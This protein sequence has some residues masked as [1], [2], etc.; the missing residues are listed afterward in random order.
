MNHSYVRQPGTTCNGTVAACT[1]CGQVTYV[2]PLHDERGGPL[3][4][5]LCAG[6]WFAEHGPRRRARRILIKALKAY[7]AAGGSTL[8]KDFNELRLAANGYFQSLVRP[9][10]RVDDDF[11]DLTSELLTA[12]IA[13]THPDKHPIERKAEANCV[14]QELHALKPFVFPAPPPKEPEPP[15][16][17]PDDNDGLLNDPCGSL[18]KLSLYFPCDDCRD[19]LPIDYCDACRAQY[20]KK[21]QEDDERFEKKRQQTNERQRKLYRQRNH[22]FRTHKRRQCAT[23]NK[24]FKHNRSDT[25]YCS[26]ACRQQ[27]YVKRDGIKVS[28]NKPRSPEIERAIKKLFTTKPDSAFTTDDLCRRVYRLEQ[29]QIERKHRAVVLPIAKKVCEQLKTWDWWY[30]HSYVFWNHVSFTSYAMRQLMHRGY[31]DKSEKQRKAAI[32]PGGGWHSEVVKGGVWWNAWQEDVAEFKNEK[33]P[34]S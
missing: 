29:I 16:D 4:C 24:I 21:Q 17:P 15:P 27:A 22:G 25:K 11:A 9:C 30:Y 33:G 6:A 34:R 23:C 28:N 7:D 18:N 19:A 26:A 32:A 8:D 13:L 3:F 10:D 5:F 31:E 20:E 14:T 1:K 2:A 12:T